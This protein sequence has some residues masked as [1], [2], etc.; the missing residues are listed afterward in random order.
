MIVF[1]DNLEYVEKTNE[2]YR[3]A[4]RFFKARKNQIIQYLYSFEEEHIYEKLRANNS[5]ISTEIKELLNNDIIFNFL[6]KNITQNV[7]FFSEIVKDYTK[8]AK[9]FKIKFSDFE[10]N[11]YE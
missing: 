4:L 7:T 10:L 5:I 8:K 2:G 1:L 3:I 11:H 9:L 6:S